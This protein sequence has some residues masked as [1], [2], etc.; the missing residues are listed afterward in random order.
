MVLMTALRRN[1]DPDT[2]S[3]NSM[4]LNFND[5]QWGQ[6]Q[7]ATYSNSYGGRMNLHRATLASDNTVYMQLDLDLGPQEVKQTAYDMGITTKLNGYPAEGLGGLRLG[8]SPLE[9]SRAYATIA[10]GGERL[11]AIAVTKITFPDGRTEV[12]F[13]QQRVRVFTDGQAYEATK[14]LRDN[15]LGLSLIHI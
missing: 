6:I 15:V 2:T 13:P 14:I 1:V 3:Y 7:V 9:M 5:P 10:N 12:P 8:V 4:P 11:R